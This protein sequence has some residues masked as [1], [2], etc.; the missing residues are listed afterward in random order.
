MKLSLSFVFCLLSVSLAKATPA[1]YIELH[2]IPKP[3]LEITFSAGLALQSGYLTR[4][5]SVGT[6]IFGVNFLT[7]GGLTTFD[8]QS[9]RADHD[10]A[11]LSLVNNKSVGLSTFSFIPHLCVFNKNAWNIYLGLGLVHVGLYQ[12]TPDY[13]LVY[14][15]FIFSGL[16]RYELSP[17]WSLHYKTQWYN[18]AQTLNDQKTSFEVWNQ[19]LGFG[20]SIF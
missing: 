16:L 8:W 19:T 9:F 5:D 6:S 3:R 4:Q 17:K 13:N 18:V 1:E 2:E 7:P 11:E 14:G 12:T 15:S 20:Y 10:T